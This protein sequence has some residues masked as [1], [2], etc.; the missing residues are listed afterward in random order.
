MEAL[1]AELTARGVR[2]TPQVRRLPVVVPAAGLPSSVDGRPTI[3]L[4]DDTLAAVGI[5]TDALFA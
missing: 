5:P 1:A 3:G 2:E 4:A